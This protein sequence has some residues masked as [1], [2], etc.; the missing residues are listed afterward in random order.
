MAEIPGNGEKHTIAV[1][2][3]NYSVKTSRNIQ[4][5][6]LSIKSRTEK[7]F[8]ARIEE[9]SLLDSY[10]RINEHFPTCDY[11]KYKKQWVK[12]VFLPGSST[13]SYSLEADKKFILEGYLGALPGES[14]EYSIK[15]RGEI[16]INRKVSEGLEFISKTISPVHG[17]IDLEISVGGPNLTGILGNFTFFYKKQDQ[18]NIVLYLV[19]ALRGDFGGIEEPGFIEYFKEGANFTRAYANSPWTGDSLPVLFSGKLKHSLVDSQLTHANLQESEFLLSEYLKTRGFT[20][21]AFIANSFLIKNSSNQGFD[22]IYLCWGD[23]RKKSLIPNEREYKSIKYGEMEEYINEFIKENQDKKL[24]LFIHTLEPHDPYELPE[25]KRYYSKEVSP[26]VLE[27]VFGDF[28]TRLTNPTE[29]QINALKALYKDEVLQSYNFFKNITGH[30]E[31]KFIINPNSMTLLTADHGERFFEHN[32][33]GHGKPDIYNE[34]LHIPLFIK[35]REF[36]SGE[37]GINVQLADIFPT[38]LD[39]LGEENL[40]GLAGDSLLKY[41][42]ETPE[43]YKNRIIYADGTHFINQFCTFKGDIKVILSDE[44]T[45]VYNLATDPEESHNLA[46]QSKYQANIQEA[47]NF[48]NSLKTHRIRQTQVVSEE[49]LER[50]KSLGYIK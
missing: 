10:S 23:N 33:W 40:T 30:L 24:F 16:L 26:E 37:Y 1:S 42:K 11:F 12:S 8:N 18:K 50:L 28:E 48:R 44:K 7:N 47:R 6:A 22:H 5:I 32:T 49:E 36:R 27:S 45:E 9:I 31:D 25:D 35:A 38:I 20:T 43:F 39:W 34:V 21:A 41:I 29:E 17:K 14:P 3:S 4:G 13:I 46:A 15:A 19:D 2:L